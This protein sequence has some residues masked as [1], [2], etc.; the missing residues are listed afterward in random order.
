MMRRRRA[1]VI[2]LGV[3]VLGAAWAPSVIAERYTGGPG[4]SSGILARPDRGWEF[5]VNAIR[6]SRGAQLGSSSTALARAQ[7]IWNSGPAARRVTLTYMDGPFPVSVP[8]GPARV[9][10][11]TRF[12]W[13]VYGTLRGETTPRM[14][15]LLDYETGR[16]DWDIRREVT[17]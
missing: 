16:L 15:G 4:G 13:T 9:E 12:G 6:A 17:R 1:I 14:I 8:G 7:Q 5:L 2:A 10:P 11:S 3:G